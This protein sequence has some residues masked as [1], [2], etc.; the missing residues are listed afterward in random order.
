MPQRVYAGMTEK[1]LAIFMSPIS[2]SSLFT[3]YF[4]N[5]IKTKYKM[6]G[7]QWGRSF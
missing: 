3:G 2:P 7:Q 6:P 4:N 5:R 1:R